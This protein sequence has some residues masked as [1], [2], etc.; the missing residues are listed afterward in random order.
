MYT[1]KNSACSPQ[2]K[3]GFESSCTISNAIIDIDK[4]STH[5]FSKI[6]YELDELGCEGLEI[7]IYF[8]INR[9][10]LIQI[11][12]YFESTSI[13]SIVLKITYS[14]QIDNDDFY[15]LLSVNYLRVF[16]L[17]MYAEN[18]IE[19][20]TRYKNFFLLKRS[21]DLT[22]AH[23]CGGVSEDYFVLNMKTFT[24]ATHA[25][26][27]LNKK[28]SI[29]S[30]GFVKNCPSLLNNFGH[31]E[32]IKLSEVAN[33]LKFREVWSV[34]KDLVNECNVCEF[35]YIC[36]DCRAFLSNPSDAFSK[37]LKCGYDPYTGKWSDWTRNKINQGAMRHYGFTE[38]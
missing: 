15:N 27:C 28:I 24:E 35:R 33:M 9:L 16:C 14:D 4:N 13:K 8:S 19:S 1:K 23:H 3:M 20:N 37:P 29:D 5:N 21:F 25:N 38:I 6:A 12:D 7:R 2:L 17:E 31:H 32:E 34:N 10:K 11:L 26:S 30:R 18:I 36:I 22:S